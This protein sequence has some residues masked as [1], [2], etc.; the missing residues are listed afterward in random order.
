MSEHH[1]F[2]V[3]KDEHAKSIEKKD[4][5]VDQKK[6]EKDTKGKG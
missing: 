4:F 3:K 5:G 1:T 6:S 2:E